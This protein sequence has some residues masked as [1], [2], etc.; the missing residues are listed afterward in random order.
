MKEK[1]VK[2]ISHRIPI[3]EHDII[4]TRYG[5]IGTVIHVYKIYQAFEVEFEDNIRTVTRY[6]IIK[7]KNNYN[8]LKKELHRNIFQCSPII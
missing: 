5:K 2:A 6:E 8:N 7:V 3:K 1:E 4:T